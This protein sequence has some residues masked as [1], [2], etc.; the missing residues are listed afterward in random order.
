VDPA[1]V[2]RWEA[3]IALPQRG[4]R[5]KLARRLGVSRED[6]DAGLAK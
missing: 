2:Y 3:G 1:T 6:L 4:I 5:A